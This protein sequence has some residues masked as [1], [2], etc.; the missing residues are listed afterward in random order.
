MVV[1]ATSVA[2][3]VVALLGMVL[4][5]RAR[6]REVSK[7]RVDGGRCV[8]GYQLVGLALPRCP[9]CGRA[10]GFDKSFEELGLSEGELRRLQELGERQAPAAPPAK[11]R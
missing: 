4:R 2:A 10:V 6:R 3:F 5:R 9:E 7:P 8:C 11:T 1:M